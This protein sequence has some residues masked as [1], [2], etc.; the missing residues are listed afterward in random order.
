[1][2]YITL[3]NGE[4]VGLDGRPLPIRSAHSAL[5]LLL[6]SAGAVVMKKAL[7]I[8]KNRLIEDQLEFAF[9]ANVHDEIQIECPP[10]IAEMIAKRMVEAIKQAGIDLNLKCPLAGEYKIGKNWAETH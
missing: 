10:E 5:N 4:L 3:K 7:I 2:N 1:M 6:Q 8:M 9:M